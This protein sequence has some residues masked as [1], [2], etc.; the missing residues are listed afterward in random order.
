MSPMPSEQVIPVALGDRAYDVVVSPRPLLA[1]AEDFL[2]TQP[3]GSAVFVFDS[4]T[5]VW[6]EPLLQTFQAAGWSTI[7]FVFPPG[8]ERKNLTTLHDACRS[9][10]HQVVDRQAIILAVGGGVVG[11]LAG[12]LAAIYLRGLR[13]IVAPTSLLAMV[14]SSV[15]GKVGVNLTQGKNLVGAFHQPMA[16]WTSLTTLSTLPEREY[17][18]GLA[19]VVK[20][21]MSLDGGFFEWLENHADAILRRDPEAL[22]PMI[23]RAVQLKAQ[24]VAEDER[25]TT[26]ARLKLNFGHTF[27]H[28]LEAA[29]R[30]LDW[31]HGE[32]VA[33]GMIKACRL[34]ERLG[35]FSS[36]ETDRLIRLLDRFDLLTILQ[37]V[38]PSWA[39]RVIKCMQSDKKR[40]AGQWRFVLPV[41]IGDV[42]I[43]S[44]VS[45]SDVKAVLVETK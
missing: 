13:W 43:V 39:D 44:G 4:N 37:V 41:R 32:A 8:E 3:T 29:T 31:L 42:A 33:W 35:R 26:G 16:V 20:Y 24:I 30:Y 34:A 1:L 19:E 15:G 45:E 14:D 38:G 17:R 12:F 5:H 7:P 21:G 40:A 25:E 10:M 18:S 2:Q 27:G 36:T 28:G 11:D 23:S 9:L 22:L 6:A